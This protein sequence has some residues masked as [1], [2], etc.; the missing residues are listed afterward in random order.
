MSDGNHKLPRRLSKPVKAD[1]IL[2]QAFAQLGLRE[3]LARH[4]LVSLWPRIVERSVASH[5]KAE[6]IVGSALLVSVDSSVWMN[7]LAALKSILLAKLNARLP[8]DAK[9]LTDI[10]FVQRSQRSKEPVS[11]PASSPASAEPS[12]QDERHLRLLLAS[13]EDEDLREAFRRVIVRDQQLKR[14]P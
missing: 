13:V 10:R 8:P 2:D 6:K 5:A 4:R 11:E 12:E 1:S 7:E 3:S 14:S 9:P